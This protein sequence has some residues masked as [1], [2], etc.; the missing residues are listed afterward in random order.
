[1]IVHY[2]SGIVIKNYI[3]RYLW[4]IRHRKT[5][6]GL[7]FKDSESATD[8]KVTRFVELV[9]CQNCLKVIGKEN[10]KKW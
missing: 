7:K 3:G 8:K 1:M 5:E 10:A 4:E 2:D 9:T 6:C